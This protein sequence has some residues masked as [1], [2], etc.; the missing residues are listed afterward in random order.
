MG[1]CTGAF[2]VHRELPGVLGGTSRAN[3]GVLTGAA[4]YWQGGVGGG[5]LI[6]GG[7][8]Y[9]HS[10]AP[11]LA[12]SFS[13]MQLLLLYKMGLEKSVQCARGGGGN[14]NGN[15]I[16]RSPRPTG[17]DQPFQHAPEYFRPT[18]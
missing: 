1:E 18:I 10:C 7:H 6:Q 3:W 11:Y 9:R 16:V 14:W 4:G 17:L 8:R 15:S 13:T 12:Q 5:G 2:Q